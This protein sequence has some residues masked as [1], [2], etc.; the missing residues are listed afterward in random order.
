MS[1]L[2][3]SIL[4]WTGWSLWCLLSC[5]AC[6]SIFLSL[7]GGWIALGLAVLYDLMHG[8]DAIGWKGLGLFAGLLIVAEIIEAGLGTLYVARKGATRYGMIGAFVGGIAGA[9]FGS[10]VMPLVGTIL[11]GIAGAFAGAV[12]GEYWRENKLEPSL[13]IGLHATIGKVLALSA[14]FALAIAG[15][16]LMLWLALPNR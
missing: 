15:A 4:A 12:A 11:G 9:I 6:F 10:S 1:E 16:V 5:A 2:G 3:G 8:F 13:R 7:P 14:K